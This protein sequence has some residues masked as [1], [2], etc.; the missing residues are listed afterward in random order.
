MG[1]PG[2]QHIHPLY[3][4]HVK[5]GVFHRRGVGR[6][7]DSAMR[8]SHHHICATAPHLGNPAVGRLHRA[9]DFDLTR[10]GAAVPFQGQR[11][12]KTDHADIQGHWQADPG[13]R[14]S[15]SQSHSGAGRWLPTLPFVTWCLREWLWQLEVLV[16]A[17]NPSLSRR[18]AAGLQPMARPV[19]RV[20]KCRLGPATGNAWNSFKN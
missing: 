16:L 1:V 19:V 3:T 9:V 12:H 20:R 6:C 17:L 4:S 2:Y 18:S 7:I 5:A 15:C 14:S 13:R 8:Q 10:Q 11:W